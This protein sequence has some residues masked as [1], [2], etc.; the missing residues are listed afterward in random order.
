[1][2]HI[3]TGSKVWGHS[4]L[5]PFYLED[6]YD[7]LVQLLNNHD[8]LGKYYFKFNQNQ[9]HRNMFLILIALNILVPTNF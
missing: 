7:G 4:P 2:K 8:L 6:A 9:A 5:P 3:K 1:M